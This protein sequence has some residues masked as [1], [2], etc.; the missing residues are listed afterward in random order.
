MNRNPFS[1]SIF[2]SCRVV[3]FQYP[4]SLWYKTQF[5]YLFAR[6]SPQF[7]KLEFFA[8][9]LIHFIYFDIAWV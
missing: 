4:L 1:F 3:L 2:T 8:V 6:L 7:E 9:A 5:V